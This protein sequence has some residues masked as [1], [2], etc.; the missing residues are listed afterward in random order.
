MEPDPDDALSYDDVAD[1]IV[2]L[3]GEDGYLVPAGVGARPSIAMAVFRRYA[4][5]RLGWTDEISN[6]GVDGP[7]NFA[8]FPARPADPADYR[9]A[10]AEMLRGERIAADDVDAAVAELA[11]RIAADAGDKGGWRRTMFE[12]PDCESGRYWRIRFGFVG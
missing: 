8:R 2:P 1:L 12:R 6:A 3:D 9:D 11:E 5:E 10:A 7:Y 4:R